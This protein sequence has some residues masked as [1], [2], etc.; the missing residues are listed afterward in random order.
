MIKALLWFSYWPDV[1]NM[2]HTVIWFVAAYIGYRI[3][4]NLAQRYF[5][6][7]EKQVQVASI[8]KTD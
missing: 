5:V 3:G 1:F 4:A 7:Q 2:N 8:N 6:Y